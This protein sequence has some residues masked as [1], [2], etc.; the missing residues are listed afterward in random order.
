MSSEELSA[1]I[2]LAEMCLRATVLPNV[3]LT[4]FVHA[5]AC[6]DDAPGVQCAATHA[7]HELASVLSV[8]SVFICSGQQCSRSLYVVQKQHLQ[9]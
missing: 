9:Y 6:E 8:A 5:G 4:K 7:A 1:D 2:R 3:M